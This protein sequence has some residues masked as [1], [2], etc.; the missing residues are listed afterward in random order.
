MRP[1]ARRYGAWQLRDYVV[2]RGTW[3]VLLG[4]AMLAVFWLSYDPKPPHW[5]FAT[6]VQPTPAAGAALAREAQQRAAMAAEWVAHE[7]QR[8]RTNVEMLLA[9]FG[10]LA[11]LI[12][13]HGIVARDRERGY[14][15]F[16]FAKP[17]EMTA[18]Y[19]TAFAIAGAG[20]LAAATG[21]LALTAVVFAR[22]VPVM[23]LAVVGAEFILLGGT[24]FLL[25]VLWRYDF[26]LAALSWPV[27]ALAASQAHDR[28][29]GAFGWFGVLEPVLPPLSRFGRFVAALSGPQLVQPLDPVF[30]LGYGALCFGAGLYL[31]RRRAGARG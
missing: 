6:P 11:T 30:V 14:Y 2:E 10:F 7:P 25:S 31:L 4:L 20:V 19:A 13:T 16:L 22:A 8:F 24:V 29:P 23:P 18:Y 17:V 21:L 28:R 12:A 5:L 9:L 15:R 1:L 26:V 3:T 27:A